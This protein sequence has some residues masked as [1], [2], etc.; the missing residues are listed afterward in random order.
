M[1]EIKTIE[2]AR[3]RNGERVREAWGKQTNRQKGRETNNTLTKARSHGLV[4]KAVMTQSCEFTPRQEP[5]Y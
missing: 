4:F 2:K 1:Q 3:W 5:K